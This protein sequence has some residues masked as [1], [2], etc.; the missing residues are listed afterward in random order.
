VD[1]TSPIALGARSLFLAAAFTSLM[2]GCLATLL[3]W[4]NVGDL[5]SIAFQGRYLIP[6]AL[7]VLLGLDLPPRLRRCALVPRVVLIGC[8]VVSQ[9]VLLWTVW[10]RYYG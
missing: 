5:G 9:L 3:Y 8:I 7:P 6:V 1:T 10:D 4:E 2:V